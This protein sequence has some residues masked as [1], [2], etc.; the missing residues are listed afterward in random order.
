MLKS[1]GHAADILIDCR[2]RSPRKLNAACLNLNGGRERTTNEP[3]PQPRLL[4]AAALP[5]AAADSEGALPWKDLNIN[6]KP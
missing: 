1:L 3:F 2:T 4:K 6:P 5:S